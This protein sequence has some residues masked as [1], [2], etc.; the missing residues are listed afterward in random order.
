MLTL[1]ALCSGPKIKILTP[2]LDFGKVTV[3]KDY[4][5]KAVL[6]NKSDIEAKYV[7]FTRNKAAGL[8]Q[9]ITGNATP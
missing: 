3:L 5:L 4:Q 1:M 7:A 6:L 9:S 8:V 2:E